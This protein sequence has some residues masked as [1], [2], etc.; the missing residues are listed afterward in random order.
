MGDWSN[1][2]LY[3]GKQFHVN[4]SISPGRQL[5]QLFGLYSV[6]Q[7]LSETE[8]CRSD[9]LFGSPLLSLSLLPSHD[10]VILLFLWFQ[11]ADVIIFQVDAHLVNRALKFIFLACSI[12][13]GDWHCQIATDIQDLITRENKGTVLL[14]RPSLICLSLTCNVPVP[15]AKRLPNLARP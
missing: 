14:M 5:I 13:V 8:F 9:D 4:N 12:V 11:V 1:Y 7:R 3:I 2:H 15:P 10:S 6:Q